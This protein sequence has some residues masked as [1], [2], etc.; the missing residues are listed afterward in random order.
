VKSAP[1]EDEL[2][3]I[4]AAYVLLTRERRRLAVVPA[5]VS[6]WRRAARLEGV[7]SAGPVRLDP[8]RHAR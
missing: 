3:A 1:G 8:D 5:P 6:R 7:D 4:V 2:V